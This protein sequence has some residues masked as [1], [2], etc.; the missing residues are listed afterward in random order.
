MKGEAPRLMR[1]TIIIINVREV[2]G[3]LG[4][5]AEITFVRYYMTL[6]LQYDDLFI[7]ITHFAA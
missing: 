6:L 5:M 2:A 7:C 1:S 4:L 3:M